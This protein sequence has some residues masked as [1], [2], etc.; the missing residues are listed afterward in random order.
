[1]LLLALLTSS[2]AGR[3]PPPSSGG[4][5]LR[6]NAAYPRSRTRLAADA[7][8]PP[9]A[10]SARAIREF[11][12][13]CLGL[14]LSS[15]VLSL[16]DTSA[17][18]LS[19]L[20]G[21]GASSLA[22]LGPATTFCDG[23]AYLFAFLNVATTNLYSSQR[24]A[25]AA[26]AE[27]AAAGRPSPDSESVVRI[28]ARLSLACGLRAKIDAAE[29]RR[30]KARV[31]PAMRCNTPHPERALTPLRCTLGRVTRLA[32]VWVEQRAR[33]WCRGSLDSG[34]LRCGE[35]WGDVGRCREIG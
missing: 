35:I 30:L 16:I 31:V 7:L 5:V 21:K 25:A 4:P 32:V 11:A 28:A 9:E 18:G 19:A 24:A 6:R 23:T 17:V 2:A 8:Q 13:P 15:P 33:G 10:P 3:R 12:L 14:W 1:M 20:P 22:A 26:A 29:V 34:G 27:G